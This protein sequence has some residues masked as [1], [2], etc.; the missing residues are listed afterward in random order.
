M[1]E[2]KYLC[3]ISF[4]F[5]IISFVG[6]IFFF[7]R[8]ELL[9]DIFI[10][11]FTGLILSFLTFLCQYFIYRHQI[12]NDIFQCYFN[13]YKSIELS[14][15]KCNG[16]HYE[17][18]NIYNE[19]KIFSNELNYLLSKFSGFVPNN[20]NK[21]YKRL[22]RSPIL[23][24]DSFNVNSIC[25]LILPNNKTR[26]EEVV[27]PL[28]DHI[29]SILVDLDKLRFNKEYEEFVRINKLLGVIK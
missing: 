3:L 2:N 25:K 21:L 13:F 14:C 10:G 12:K 24:Y 17:V 28:K 26:F 23:N 1:K 16:S 19:L 18:L 29:Q 9:Y 15:L 22:N 11:A 27:I 6:V 7:N 4:V 20:K 8:N 5:L